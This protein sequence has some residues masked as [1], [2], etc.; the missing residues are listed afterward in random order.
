MVTVHPRRYATILVGHSSLLVEGLAR[1]LDNTEFQVIAR[2][3][4]VDQLGLKDLHDHKTILLIL[5]ADG[6]VES[7]MRQIEA[8]KQ[9]HADP[10]IAIVTR[11][12]RTADMALLFQAGANVCFGESTNVA[13]FLKTLEL[14]MLGQTLLPASMLPPASE[15]EE[16]A[17]A[18]V[19]GDPM[20][21]SP[22]ELRILH[23]LAEG[24]SNKTIARDIGAAESTVKVHVKS[25]LR[26]IGV[27]NRTQAAVWARNRGIA[28]S[29]ASSGRPS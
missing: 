13:I 7:A 19:S 15:V 12:R 24:Q 26:K 5:D 2:A 22:Q 21:L 9:L 18:P 1:L 27:N 14:V 28:S 17:P 25:I 20:R 23:R 6:G 16:R 29:E 10:R 3:P 11:G 8:F 4:S